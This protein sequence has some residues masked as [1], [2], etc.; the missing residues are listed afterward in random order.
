MKFLCLS[1]HVQY[2]ESFKMENYCVNQVEWAERWAIALEEV[3]LKGTP[4]SA[5]CL[6]IILPWL[7]RWVAINEK[8]SYSSEM[9]AVV[10]FF[11]CSVMALH[12]ISYRILVTLLDVNQHLSLSVVNAQAYQIVSRYPIFSYTQFVFVIWLH[13]SWVRGE[14]ITNGQSYVYL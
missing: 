14:S 6:H 4:I 9:Y 3:F 2:T 13:T 11:R 12:T 1:S 8:S 10:S 5:L 7:D